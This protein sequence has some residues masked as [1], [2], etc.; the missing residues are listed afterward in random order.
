MEYLAVFTVGL[1]IGALSFMKAPCDEECKN[2]I[3]R[4]KDVLNWLKS[5]LKDAKN[6]K[7]TKRI[8]NNKVRLLELIIKKLEK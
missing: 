4:Q 6:K 8:D 1:I 5:A 2:I 7:L 3:K